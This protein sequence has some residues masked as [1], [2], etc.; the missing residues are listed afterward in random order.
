MRGISL[1]VKPDEPKPDGVTVKP[2]ELLMTVDVWVV[3][4]SWEPKCF[5][6]NE[7]YDE[8]SHRRP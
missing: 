4:D 8:A 5:H 3:W 7:V 1:A 2:G 6:S